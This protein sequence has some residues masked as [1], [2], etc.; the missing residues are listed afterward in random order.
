MTQEKQAKIFLVSFIGFL[1]ANAGWSGFVAARAGDAAELARGVTSLALFGTLAFFLCKRSNGVR[2]FL[3]IAIA[4][5]ALLFF[6]SDVLSSVHLVTAVRIRLG[7][8][9]LLGVTLLL[10]RPIR[11][12]TRAKGVPNKHPLPAPTSGTP[13]AGA[14]VASPSGAAGR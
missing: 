13:A 2:V 10:W 5:T 12:Y 8:G 4:A 11:L 7:I 14:P 6:A 9:G 3:G 1:V